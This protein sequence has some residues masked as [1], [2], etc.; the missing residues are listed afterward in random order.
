MPQLSFDHHHPEVDATAFVAENATLVGQVRVQAG[1]V[2]M[3]GV[4]LR[5]D[6]EH[7]SL[8]EGSN[9]QDNVVVHGDTG[10]PA[11]IG[12]GVSVGHGAIVHGATIHDHCLIGMGATLLN[13]SVIGEGSLIAAGTVVLEGTKI[14][15]GSL[16]AGIPGV[17]RRELTEQ[18]RDA[19]TQNALTY[20]ELGRTYR[21]L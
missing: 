10:F 3:F 11:V 2:V 4:V 5:A 16:V 8:G 17:V 20:Q 15:P 1:S 14:P 21:G 13:G 18:E 7:I 12:K 19:I 9:L 6:R